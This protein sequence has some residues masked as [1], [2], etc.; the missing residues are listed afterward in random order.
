MRLSS[1]DLEIVATKLAAISEEMCLTL[2]RTSRSLYVKETADFC[3]AI[4]GRDGRFVAYPKAIG[5][6]GFVGLNLLDTVGAAE[7][8]GPLEPGDVIVANDP[9]RTGGLATHLPDIQMVAPYF[10]DGEVFAYGWAFIHCSDIGGRVPSSVTPFNDSIFAEGL[11]I[12]PVRLVR[13]GGVV[14]D[15][16]SLLLANTRTP[17]ANRGDL[18]AMVNALGTGRRRVADMVAQHGAALVVDGAAHAVAQTSARATAAIR[19]LSSG[20]YRFIDFLDNDAVSAVPVRISV[21]VTV[22]DGHL[23][24]DFRGTDPQVGSAFNIASFGRPHAWLTTRILALIGTIDPDIALNGGLMDVISIN[25]AEGSVVNAVH[26]AAVGV[27]HATASRVNDALSGALIQAA[28]LIVPAASSGVVIPVVLAEETATG[29]NVQVVEPMVGGT[30]GRFGADG[31]DG[32]DA[33]ISN[34]SNN[35]VETVEAELGVHILR[36]GLRPGSGG[37]GRWRGGMGLELIFQVT[38]DA[39]LLARGLERLIFRPWGAEGGAPGLPTELVINEGAEQE[40]RPR[41]VDVLPLRPGDV[42]TIRTP[43]GGG[44]GDPFARDPAKVAEDVRRGLVS[45]ERARADYGVVVNA[46]HRV[47]DDATD[48]LR[49]DPRTEQSG[50]G[51]ARVQWDRVFTEDVHDT[52]ITSLGRV[53]AT[54]R[55]AIKNELV[56]RVLAL[57][58]PGFPGTAAD[59]AA[60]DQA[61]AAFA[62]RVQALRTELGQS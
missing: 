41:T 8:N 13:Q 6:S 55:S 40:L 19:S 53:P 25:A 18:Q 43:G 58:P 37:P 15:V 44:Y 54:R 34:L 11:Q 29:Q 23:H 52:L 46:D 5:V 24:I 1:V 56:G 28:P 38:G 26:P 12:P 14:A 62:E 39:S 48:R 17:E 21:T 61:K 47:D 49:A 33:G 20:T 60:L 4:A 3:C 27:R 22:D 16:E 7:A 45:P 35:P 32:R 30:G 2:Q 50:A 59:D 36:Y 42:V 9:Y 51:S 57:L 10:V 31:V